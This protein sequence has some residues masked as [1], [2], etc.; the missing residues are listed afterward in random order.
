MIF[1]YIS[2]KHS[3]KRSLVLG[4]PTRL[5]VVES[6]KMAPCKGKS[7]QQAHRYAGHSVDFHPSNVDHSR[8][9]LHK[10]HGTIG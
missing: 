1:E 4:M 9:C 8:L 3:G 7:G 10:L 2:D 6:L 5:V